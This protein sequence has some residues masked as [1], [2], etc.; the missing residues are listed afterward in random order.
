MKGNSLVH[1]QLQQAVEELF[2]LVPEDLKT[3][4]GYDNKNYLLTAEGQQWI[5]KT[6]ADTALKPLLEEESRLL[7]QLHLELNTPKPKKSKH[8]NAVETVDIQGQNV[9]IRVLTFVDGTFLAA[10]DPTPKLYYSLGLQVAALSNALG[11]LQSPLTQTRHWAWHLN[12]TEAVREKLEDIEAP[13]KKRVLHLFIQQFEQQ[14]LPQK[15]QLPH[16]LLHND[17]NECNLL[18]DGQQLSGCID[19]GDVAYGPRIYEL[20]IVLVYAGYDKA[21]CLN[22]MSKVLMGYS[23]SISLSTQEVALLYYAMGMRICLSLCNGAAAKAQDPKNDYI[24]HSEQHM[25]RLLFQWMALGPIK[26]TNT[27]LKAAGI[28]QPPSPTTESVLA[29]R[30]SVLGAALSVSYKQPVHLKAA[31]LQYM[32]GANGT[33]FLDAYNNIPHVGHNHPKVVEAAQKQLARLNTNTRYLYDELHDYASQLLSHF[34]DSLCRVFFVNSGSEA[35][36]LAI[37]MARFHTQ[38]KAIAVVAHGYHGHTQVGI[39]I[40]DYKFNHPQGIG[41]PDHIVKLP[42]ISKADQLS[43]GPMWPKTEALLIERPLAAFI[44]ETILGCAGQVPLAAGYLEKV[45]AQVRAQGGLCIADEV[46]TGFGRVGTHFW[47]FE[48]QGVIPDMVVIGKPMGNG[49]PMGAVVCTEAISSSFSK[50]VEFFSSFGGNPVS[51]AIGKSVLEVIAEEQLQHAALETGNYY[52]DALKALQK[53]H[54]AIAEVRGSGLFLGIAIE[55]EAL[56]PQPQLASF[57]KN[58]LREQQVLISTDGPFNNVLKTKPPLC[59][60]KANVDQVVALLDQGLR[61]FFP[62]KG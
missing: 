46:Q 61:K 11:K 49:H 25:E 60:S 17:L 5:V 43:S 45:Y 32:Y 38:K 20:V 48:Q 15:H 56:Q 51:C 40:S 10:V 37:R 59:F 19:F 31:A 21:D 6:Y 33:T 18:V 2:L 24:S 30:H 55:D 29:Q 52:T 3:L 27:F 54:S 41:Q 26:V 53:E 36:D 13:E 47:A 34:P 4:P 39:E 23:A 14:L 62:S 42:L 58:Y 35:S 7:E 28:S 9:L 22:W 1:T 50:G 16:R 44:S 8:H 12:A 57:L